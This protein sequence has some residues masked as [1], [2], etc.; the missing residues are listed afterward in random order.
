[1]RREDFFFENEEG[2]NIPLNWA[3]AKRQGCTNNDMLGIIDAHHSR[4]SLSKIME[5]INGDDVDA[6]R[7]LTDVVES[8]EFLLQVFWHFDQDRTKHSWPRMKRITGR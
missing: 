1:M 4:V 7:Y 2:I 8:I 3:L 5:R 6:L